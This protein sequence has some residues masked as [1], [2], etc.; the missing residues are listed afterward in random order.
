M[1]D[2][3]FE[4]YI[5]NRQVSTDT[6]QLPAGAL[7]F[8]LKGER[9]D[10]N[11]YAEQALENGAAYAVI[12]SGEIYRQ[13][14]QKDRLLLVPDALAALQRLARQY[15]DTLEI[16]FIGIGGSNGKTTTKELIREVLSKKYKTHATQ[17]NLNNHIGVPLTLLSVPDEAEIAVI[18]LGTNQPGDISLL[19]EICNPGF[20]LITNIGKEHLEGFGSLENV[21]KEE[22]ELYRHLKKVSG[23]A[24]VNS[25]DGRLTEMS[26][27]LQRLI[28]YGYREEA[29]VRGK[30]LGTQPGVSF[31]TGE[32]LT[33]A[34]HLPG[35]F[36]LSNILAAWAV[37]R[38]FGVGER[39][40]KEAIES[41]VPGNNR[42]QVVKKS[43]I[44]F[45]LDC[46][47]A[48]P[49]SMEAALISFAEMEGTEKIA[50]LGDML[51]LGSHAEQEH[52]EILS[53]LS[54]LG[55]SQVYLVG[56]VF[57]RVNK[58]YPAFL[59]SEELAVCFKEKGIPPGSA[60]FLKGS[61]GMAVEKSV[62]AFL[63]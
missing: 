2:K 29:F 26:G 27:E 49:S 40:M 15:R 50:V 54:R 53:L 28:T 24:F 14:H 43:G 10:G 20:G 60:V 41:Y 21:A 44:S 56:P 30:L 11:L 32:G 1:Q 39:Q 46:Y 34:S 31:E 4:I 3:I 7:F 55:L 57:S 12:D 59:T 18:E 22:L 58:D 23:L 25:D 47:N 8:S 37:G 62:A 5:K 17:G 19:L 51:E 35:S 33:V 48:N 9:F 45:F 16:P 61:R 36:N 42:S 13:S 6:R 38:H 63:G 52:R